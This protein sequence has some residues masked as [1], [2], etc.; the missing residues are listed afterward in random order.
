MVVSQKRNMTLRAVIV[1][2]VCAGVVACVNTTTSNDSGSSLTSVQAQAGVSPLS[3]P[4]L[5]AEGEGEDYDWQNDHIFVKLSTVESGGVLT[6]VQD[7]VKPGFDLALHL[8]DTHTEIFYVLDGEI[9]WTVNNESFTTTAGSVVYV[10]GGVPHGASSDAGGK[11]LMFYAPAGF[12]NMLAA[13][14]GSSWIQRINPIAISRRQKKYDFRKASAGQEAAGNGP[15]A[16]YLRE[17]EGSQSTDETGDSTLKLS[18]EQTHGLATLIE[19]NLKPGAKREST[20]P[21]DY[22]EVLFVLE[23]EIEVAFADQ[24]QVA[25]AG[26]TVFFPSGITADVVSS[27][28]AKLL[29]YQTPNTIVK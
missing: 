15:Q 25:S 9:D 7:N 13:I 10:P 1:M 2:A 3:A 23:G 5:R 4:L 24:V 12:D 28:G 27:S 20:R 29:A 26:A 19:Q 21:T 8:H 22:L 18:S 6:L 11:M 17:G 16:V 14:E